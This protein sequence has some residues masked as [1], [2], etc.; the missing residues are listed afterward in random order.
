MAVHLR[1]LLSLANDRQAIPRGKIPMAKSVVA[2]AVVAAR[3]Q[4]RSWQG[5]MEIIHRARVRT[6]VRVALE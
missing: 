2:D 6:L 5:L 4:W 3:L 1:L